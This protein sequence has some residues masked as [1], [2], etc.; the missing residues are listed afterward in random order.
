M[1]R[2]TCEELLEEFR[3][4]G[5]RTYR[6]TADLLRACGFEGRETARGHA[7]WK[8]RGIQVTIPM[9]RDLLIIYK[10]L[11]ERSILELRFLDE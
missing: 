8:N 11:V 9:K 10:K 1:T 5:T 4:P 2:S 7:I 3:R 6:E